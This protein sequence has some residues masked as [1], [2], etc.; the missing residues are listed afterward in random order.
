MTKYQEAKTQALHDIRESL[1][2]E[3]KTFIN[4]SIKQL[5]IFLINIT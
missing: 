3:N 4:V 1:K 5:K 2:E